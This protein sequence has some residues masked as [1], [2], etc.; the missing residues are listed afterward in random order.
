[1]SIV[2]KVISEYLQHNRRLVVPAFG[3]FIVKESGETIFSDLL[4]TDD[5]V[6]TSL[7][8]RGGLTEMEAAVTIDRFIF[9]VRHELEQFG[10]CRL[11]DIGM[12]RL[13]PATKSMRL[14]PPVKGEMPKQTPYVLEPVKD[15]PRVERIESKVVPTPMPTPAPQSI[16]QP[17]S[18]PIYQSVAAQVA[19]PQPQ[20]QPQPRKSQP[21]A[22]PRKK[23]DFVLLVAILI[24]VAA[25]GAILY[26]RYVSH[27]TE[28]DDEVM[29]ALRVT[30]EQI[31]TD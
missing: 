2:V 4:R 27:L 7:L 13:E 30:P 3:A 20:S 5:G 24:L 23:F 15:E 9:E 16:P 11:G 1:M 26:G 10:C 14:Y 8:C 28:G 22:A 29:D 31:V 17:I 25:L 21:K 12:L 6:L 19:T 18:Q